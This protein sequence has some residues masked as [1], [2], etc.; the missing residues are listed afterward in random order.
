[1][2]TNPIGY[3]RSKRKRGW[4]LL[5]GLLV[6]VAVAAGLVA[7]AFPGYLRGEVTFTLEKVSLPERKPD[8]GGV[9]AG[10]I[11]DV[12]AA[13][14]AI[15]GTGSVIARVRVRNGMP[16][17]GAV[18]AAHYVIV[19]NEKEV[20]H[21]NWD[22][23]GSSIAL[24]SGEE[25]VLELPFELDTKTLAGSAL[26]VLTGQPMAVKLK[27]EATITVVGV[28]VNA[29]FSLSPMEVKVSPGK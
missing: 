28:S 25:A 15:T 7:L 27:G 2:T 9:L 18:T 13:A 1:M 20:G 21:G 29:P 4:K 6:L 11:G 23:G 26:D 8:S 10:I 19:I 12:S 16:L 24:P 3:P 5:A 14:K 17:S 22:A